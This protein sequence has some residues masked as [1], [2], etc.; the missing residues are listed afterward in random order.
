ML[1]WASRQ[2]SERSGAF[3]DKASQDHSK[4]VNIDLSSSDRGP[5]QD[6]TSQPMAAGL[7]QAVLIEV[8]V[9]GVNPDWP[10]EGGGSRRC[11]S[12]KVVAASLTGRRD[13]ADGIGVSVVAVPTD[14]AS[15]KR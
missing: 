5:E 1:F 13:R 11:E 10:P 6:P 3:A 12:C 9:F 2:V 14:T 15:E 7:S 8:D 4:S